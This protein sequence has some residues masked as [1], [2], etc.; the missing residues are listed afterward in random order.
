MGPRDA[1]PYPYE[2]G[3]SGEAEIGTLKVKYEELKYELSLC[4]ESLK[5]RQKEIAAARRDIEN[6]QNEVEAMK[7]QNSHRDGEHAGTT[8]Q[9]N[10]RQLSALNNKE[11]TPSDLIYSIAWSPHKPR[12]FCA[13]TSTFGRTRAVTVQEEIQQ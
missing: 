5:E 11:V 8:Y 3:Q 7:I 13:G 1:L 10:I 6:L 2:I 9:E 4:N 12:R